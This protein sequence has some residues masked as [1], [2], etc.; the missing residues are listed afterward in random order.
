[1]QE[2]WIWAD[3]ESV[4]PSMDFAWDDDE[5]DPEG[6]DGRLEWDDDEEEDLDEEWDEDDEEDDWEEWEEEF[7]DDVDDSFSRRRHGRPEW[8]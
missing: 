6:W 2:G 1:M 4:F 5:E 3:D 7:E 8:N